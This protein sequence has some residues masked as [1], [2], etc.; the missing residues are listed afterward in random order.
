MAL[1]FWNTFELYSFQSQLFVIAA[2]N[3][4]IKT[5]Y[6]KKRTHHNSNMNKNQKEAILI[7]FLNKKDKYKRLAEHI[8]QLMKNDPLMP[9][10]SLHTIIYR[11]KN[12]SRLIEKIIKLNQKTDDS[13]LILEQ[14]YQERINDLLGVR[15]ICLR[16]SDVENVEAYLKLLSEDNILTFLNGPEYKRSFILPANPGD[17]LPEVIDLRYTGYSSIH[18]QIKLGQNADAPKELKDIQFELQLRTILEEAWSEIDH[19]YRYVSSRSGVHLPEDINTGFYS[20]SAYLQ[21]AALQAEHLCRMAESHHLKKVSKI[22]DIA[23]IVQDD[24]VSANNM[25]KDEASHKL[26]SFEIQNSLQKIVGFKITS[27][28]LIYIQ[29]RLSEINSVEKPHKTL[30]KLL[31]K[32]RLMEFKSIF[33]EILNA[34]PFAKAKDRNIDLINALNFSIFWDSQGKKVAHEG[35]R[36]VLKWRKNSSSC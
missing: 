24:D 7:S 20:L 14:N 31:S 35:L 21:V 25:K 16:L 28:T 34:A 2:L 11:I 3:V 15:M 27:R 33:K 26:I 12:E 10:E 19:K 29:K 4:D 5:Y 6:Q 32:N 30:Q 18:Y 1:L 17:A 22:K 23:Q 13:P 8:V 36:N 9:K